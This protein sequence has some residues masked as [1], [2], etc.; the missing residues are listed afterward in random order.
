METDLRVLSDNE[1]AQVH[2][3]TLSILA[4]KGVRVDT[5]RGRKILKKAGADVDSKSNIVRFPRSLVEESLRLAPKKFK[6]GG[7]RPGWEF[8]VNENQC[9]LLADGAAIYVMD[10]DTA[11]RREA[12]FAD[13]L[14][15]TRLID[16]LDEV[17]VYWSMVEA[18]FFQKSMG[19]S[20]RYWR[21]MVANFSKHLQDCSYTV[22]ESRW[23]LEVL[24]TVFGGKQEIKK[25]NPFSFL[26]TP[27]SPLVI[28]A[29]HTDAYLETIEWGFPAAIMPMPMMGGTA[30]ASLISTVMLSNCETL[31]M[32]CLIQAAAPG[33]PVLYAPA[34]SII[35]PHT[36]RYT[37]GEVEHG[38]LGTAVTEMARHYGLPVEASAG[39]PGHYIPGVRS[40][41]E[42]ALS[43][44]MAILS[45]PDLLVGPGQL[46]GAMILSLEQLM[47]DVEIF[48]RCSRLSDG[49]DTSVEEWLEVD[50]AAVEHGANFLGRRSTRNAMRSGEV[51]VSDF[52]VRDSY[53]AWSS[54]GRPTL[55][56]EVQETLHEILNTHQS[57]PLG[58][59]VERELDKIER[60]A[61]EMEAS[62][63]RS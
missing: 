52:N 49:I 43:W 12:T 27:V 41:Y 20:V 10:P 26:L 29:E 42:R 8:P 1:I 53:E 24:G 36:G 39:N 57:L 13:W 3:R 2:E 37:G 56:D 23:M 11:E 54:S 58:E 62:A 44:T 32:V 28:E 19:D 9:T 60:R 22:E 59:D 63:S 46:S 25:S 51:Y 21:E 31:A 34:P 6:L 61:R 18:T 35:D 47:I 5:D 50:L 33:T 55:V 17:G 30:P 15:A 48:R 4:T 38:L 7:R 45:W 40:G 14:D 16:A